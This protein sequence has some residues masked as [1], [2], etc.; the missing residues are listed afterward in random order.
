MAGHYIGQAMELPCNYLPGQYMAGVPPIYADNFGSFNA[1]FAAGSLEKTIRKGDGTGIYMILSEILRCRYLH[2][3]LQQPEYQGCVRVCLSQSANLFSAQALP[4]LRT[5]LHGRQNT[6]TFHL[7]NEASTTGVG[8]DGKC[9]KILSPILPASL[10]LLSPPLC[11]QGK[12]IG[13]SHSW[14]SKARF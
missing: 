5:S 14:V 9:M 10:F 13:N 6:N 8:N 7:S 11:F 12:P 3:T 2:T 4:S 1:G